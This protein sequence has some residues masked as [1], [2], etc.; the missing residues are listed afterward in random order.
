MGEA[1]FLQYTLAGL[2]T[3]AG[4]TLFG[5]GMIVSVKTVNL[6]HKAPATRHF[7]LA[8]R[9]TFGTADPPA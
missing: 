2:A 1:D 8:A 3:T 7:G 5:F 9:L 4:V 6:W